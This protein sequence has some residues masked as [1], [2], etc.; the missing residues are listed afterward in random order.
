M[1]WKLFPHNFHFSKC[2]NI[3]FC[4]SKNKPDCNRWCLN[5]FYWTL[6]GPGHTDAH[7]C[8]CVDMDDVRDEPW[9]G[10]GG[11]Y[12]HWTF[13]KRDVGFIFR[14]Q[15]SAW[16]GRLLLRE[17]S[18]RGGSQ[19]YSNTLYSLRDIACRDRKNSRSSSPSRVWFTLNQAFL[20]RGWASVWQVR[21]TQLFY[22]VPPQKL[23]NEILELS[24][25]LW[26]S[27]VKFVF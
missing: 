25:S 20:P 1:Y 10:Y 4:L 16:E 11:F 14:F 21:F 9:R 12:S 5:E 19:L 24:K 13:L 22:L 23:E 2:A 26:D 15:I 7:C 8:T 27:V 18:R 17:V 3:G 6:G